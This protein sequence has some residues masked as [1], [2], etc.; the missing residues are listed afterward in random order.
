LLYFIGLGL[1]QSPSL[2]SLNILKEC[3]TIYY[4]SYTSPIISQRIFDDLNEALPGKEIKSVKRE[5]VEDGRS[6][7]DTAKDSTIALVCSGDPMIATTHQELRYRAMK[8]GVQTRVIHGSSVISAVSGELGLHSYNFGRSV[9][10]TREPMQY[11]S[12]NTIFRNLLQGLHTTLLLEWD[13][14]SDFFLSPGQAII[15]L[16][17]AEKDLRSEVISKDTLVLVVSRLGS[18]DLGVRALSFEEVM[19]LDFGRPPHV[20]VVPGTLHFTEREA[21]GAIFEKAPET[22]RDNSEGLKRIAE[23]MVERYSAKTFGALTRA[24][25]AAHD[26]G[27]AARYA[28]VFEN[29]ECYTQDA[30]RFLNEG[31]EE[32]AVL[33]IGYAEGLLDSL[34]FSK[35]LEFDW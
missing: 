2:K 14:S 35:Q 32:L 33:S 15:S 29:V 21:L 16:L 23:I 6:I 3:A 22:F 19:I 1:E 26:S 10:V 34:R 20:L 4:E 7:L 13:E 24:R 18:E 31:K 28:D 11:T 30:R 25:K 17:E 27:I 9:T 5:F 8:R 12:Y